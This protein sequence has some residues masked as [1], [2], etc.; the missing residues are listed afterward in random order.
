MPITL[1]QL[2]DPRDESYI[3][4]LVL[5]FSPFIRLHQSYLLVHKMLLAVFFNRIPRAQFQ[6]DLPLAQVLL[7]DPT[8]SVV[9]FAQPESHS[10]S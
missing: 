10:Q 8:P 1:I 2:E 4:E 6:F 7:P 3:T 5:L 9:R